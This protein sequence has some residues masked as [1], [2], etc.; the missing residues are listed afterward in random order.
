MA[1]MLA[2]LPTNFAAQEHLHADVDGLGGTSPPSADL[3]R[4][5]WARAC[6]DEA[7]RLT[8]VVSNE[9]D[10]LNLSLADKLLEGDRRGV[11]RV[12]RVSCDA[13]R[14]RSSGDRARLS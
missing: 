10:L 8:E 12:A 1:W 6:V 3:D 11:L 2:L 13:H 4:L 5:S 14:P 7:E 9:N